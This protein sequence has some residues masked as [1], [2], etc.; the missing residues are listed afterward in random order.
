MIIC[1][2]I[3]KNKSGVSLLELMV[4]VSL[5][6]MTILLASTIFQSVIKSQREAIVSQEMQE[7]MRYSFEKL[8]KEIRTAQKDKDKTCIPSGRIYWTDGTKLIF[9]NYHK[10]CVCYY[11][12]SGRLMISDQACAF[13][14]PLTPGKISQL[15]ALMVK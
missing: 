14:L 13:G 11:L 4:A 9:L 3:I 12:D 1:G 6:A 8:G 10:E 5:F 15:L 7:N 2:N